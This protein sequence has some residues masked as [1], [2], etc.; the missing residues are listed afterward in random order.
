MKNQQNEITKYMADNNWTAVDGK[1]MMYTNGKLYVFSIVSGWIISKTPDQSERY[2]REYKNML[3][4]FI[5][6][7]KKL[8]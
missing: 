5:N 1:N 3:S 6:A 7:D 2:S 8:K 4:A